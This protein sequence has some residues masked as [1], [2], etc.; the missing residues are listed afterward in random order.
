MS[1]SP[2]DWMTSYPNIAFSLRSLATCVLA[3]VETSI[4]ATLNPPLN[5]AKIARPSI[6]LRRARARM[7]NDAREWARYHGFDVG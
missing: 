7:A 6:P 5:L 3:D 2:S 4:L 1:S